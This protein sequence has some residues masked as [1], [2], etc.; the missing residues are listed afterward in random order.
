MGN[1]IV[2]EFDRKKLKKMCLLTHWCRTCKKEDKQLL[3]CHINRIDYK[4]K[5]QNNEK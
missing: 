5:E 1:K 4:I 2:V 3:E